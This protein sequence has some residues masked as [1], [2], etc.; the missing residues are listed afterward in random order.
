MRKTALAILI[1]VPLV[2]LHAASVDYNRDI[3]PILSEYCFHCHGNDDESRKGELRLDTRDAALKGGESGDEA[4][5]PGQ[6]EKSAI[7]ARIIT[8]DRDDVMPPPKTHKVLTPAQKAV[9]DQHG[10]MLG[11]RGLRHGPRGS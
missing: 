11:Q 3:Q 5:V 8:D 7:I 4:I 1:A 2:R 6:P 10:G 9:V